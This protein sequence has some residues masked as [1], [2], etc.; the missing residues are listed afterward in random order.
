MTLKHFSKKA[1]ST[2]L[3]SL[4]PSFVL[5]CFKLLPPINNQ[6]SLSQRDYRIQSLLSSNLLASLKAFSLFFKAQPLIYDNLDSLLPYLERIE[7]SRIGSI[8]ELDVL[9]AMNNTLMSEKV[10]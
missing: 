9:V 3:I 6:F 4:I 10:R 7:V 2:Q 5:I 1:V 8:S